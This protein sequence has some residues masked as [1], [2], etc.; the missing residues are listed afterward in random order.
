MRRNFLIAL[1]LLVCCAAS[2]LT[3]D[4][5]A[6]GVTPSAFFDNERNLLKRFYVTDPIFCAGSPCLSAVGD[7]VHD[8]TSAIIAADAAAKLVLGTVVFLPTAPGLAYKTTAKVPVNW[9]ANWVCENGGTLKQCVIRAHSS[10]SG[11]IELRSTFG[12]VTDSGNGEFASHLNYFTLDANSLASN[13]IVSL[14]GYGSR[15]NGVHIINAPQSCMRNALFTIP[16]TISAVTPGGGNTSP[17]GVTVSIVDPYFLGRTQWVGAAGTY[18]LKVKVTTTGVRDAGKFAFSVDNGVTYQTLTQFVSHAANIGIDDGTGDVDEPSGIQV[19]FPA[20]T[21]NAPDTYA[22]SVTTTAADFATPAA[23]NALMRYDDPVFDTCGT[24]YA[25][26][27]VIGSIGLGGTT[28]VAPGTIA[29]TAGSSFLIGTSTTFTSQV[30]AGASRGFVW[31]PTGG[32]GTTYQITGALSDTVLAIDGTTALLPTVTLSGLD[33][34]IGYW[35]GLYDDGLTEAEDGVI[36]GGH[37]TR[38]SVCMQIAGSAGI[39]IVGHEL[40]QCNLVGASFGS[41]SDNTTSNLLQ[42]VVIDSQSRLGLYFS[43]ISGGVW[44][45]P[46]HSN[47]SFGGSPLAWT[48]NLSGSYS[49]MS[50][51]STTLANTGGFSFLQNV[52]M[53]L[54]PNIQTITS[55]GQTLALPDFTSLRNTGAT[56]FIRAGANASYLMTGKLFPDPGGPGLIIVLENNSPFRLT[57]QPGNMTGVTNLQLEAPYVTLGP[58]EIITFISQTSGGLQTWKQIGSIG[59]QYTFNSAGNTGVGERVITTVSSTTPTEIYELDVGNAGVSPGMVGHFDIDAQSQNGVNVGR[60]HDCK[61]LYAVGGV[62]SAVLCDQISGTSSGAPPLGWAMSV[63]PS[64]TTPIAKIYVAGD[65]SANTVAWHIVFT[66]RDPPAPSTA[67]TVSAPWLAEC[68][69]PPRRRR[70]AAN[71]NDLELS[72][73]A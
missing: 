6:G 3:T 1:A 53:R 39:T 2:L 9:P 52:M 40:Q 54:V 48:I 60:W 30:G 8:D 15:F 71:D 62:R 68:C 21:Y 66:H 23:A 47:V 64:G 25:T 26:A 46:H 43:Q 31:L 13:G 36:I 41:P 28:V 55:A 69:L 7:D 65:V 72:E 67:P 27:G 73:A 5:H 16:P 45:Q 34:A 33:Y 56:S 11:V 61:V 42:S 49:G 63:D 44:E 29:V 50:T 10:M 17:A 32:A 57:L 51:P 18:P 19:Q 38:S 70:R 58:G 59:K 14:G 12:A 22:F 24:T 4:V 20:G 35:G 37:S